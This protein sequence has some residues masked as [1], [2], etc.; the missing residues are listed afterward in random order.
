M[1]AGFLGVVLCSAALTLLV[2][3]AGMPSSAQTTYTSAQNVQPVFEGWERNPDGTF[4]MVFGY[5]NRNYVE[6][7][8]VPVGADNAFAPGPV[9]R[10]QPTHFYPRRQSFVFKVQVPADWGE[11]T[12]LVWTVTHNGRTS[13]AIGRLWPVWELDEF[14]WLANRTGDIHARP[15]GTTVGARRPPSIRVVGDDN[16]KVTLPESIVLTVSASG[17]G[18]PARRPQPVASQTSPEPQRSLHPAPGTL[19]V[20][21]VPWT[22]SRVGAVTQDMVRWRVAQET[23]LAV[24]WLHYRGPGKITFEP[25]AVPI[26]PDDGQARTT[27]RFSEPG[28]YV[29]RAVADNRMYTAPVDV[30]VVVAQPGTR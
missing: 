7:L 3:A 30:T 1:R 8:E 4:N 21:G 15:V 5:M 6:E 17:A 13:K 25:Q 12:D 2:S 18:E 9:D 20:N 11:K 14:V 29:V 24:S 10:G 27:V 28:T 16:A 22:D 23:G 19:S 26:K